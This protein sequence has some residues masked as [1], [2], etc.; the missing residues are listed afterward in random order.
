MKRI[1]IGLRQQIAIFQI[2]CFIVDKENLFQFSWAGKKICE[3]T[4]SDLDECALKTDKCD[5]NAKCTN[6]NG[7]YNCSCNDGY[8]GTGFNCTGKYSSSK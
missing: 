6:M 4:V 7:T 5:D 2:F 1:I 8:H 3:P